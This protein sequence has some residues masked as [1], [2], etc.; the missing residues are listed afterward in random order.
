M[1]SDRAL[2]IQKIVRN[3]RPTMIRKYD[4]LILILVLFFSALATAF[5]GETIGNNRHVVLIVWDGMRPDFVSEERTPVLWKLASDGVLFRRHHAVY[6]SMTEVNGV[7]L[8]TGVYPSRN[9][10]IANHEYRPA[11]NGKKSVD[12]EVPRVVKAGDVASH[13]KYLGV[14]TIAELVRKAGRQSIVAGAKGVALLFDRHL[15]AD[16]KGNSVAL[17]AGNTFPQNA[18][19][20]LVKTLGPFA[21]AGG[22]T[23]IQRD[24]WTV[25]AFTDVL[26]KSGLPDFSLLW[27]GQPDLTEH[28]FAPGSKETLL[29]IRSADE[30]L[31]R[32]LAALDQQNARQTTDLFVVSDHGFSTIERSIDLRKILKDAAFDAVTEFVNEPKA[33]QIMMVGN[34]GTVLFYVINHDTNTI[35]RLVE[36]LQRSDFASVIFTQEPVVGTFKFEEARIDSDHAPDVEM[37]FRWTNSKNQFG[38]P[39]MIDADWNRAAGKGTHATLSRFDMHATL[40]TAGP[41]FR[42]GESDD[43]PTG[44]IDLAPTILQVLGIRASQPLDGRILSEAMRSDDLRAPKSETLS[45]EQERKFSDGTWRQSLQITRIGSTVYFDEGNGAFIRTKTALP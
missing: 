7:A 40:I 24:N 30:N 3:L 25:K 9:G 43:L 22:V 6:P 5:A 14:P 41:D 23:A 8:A 38:V 18:L 28:E 29:A 15:G 13:G 27:L 37:A 44:N 36:F 21:P 33:G 17:F 16:S 35:R 20:L 34:G 4:T 26:W 19:E 11:I 10:M 12:T 45:I 42:R 39:G 32:V 1:A 2:P 31:G